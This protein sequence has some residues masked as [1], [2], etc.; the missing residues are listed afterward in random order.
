VQAALNA[1]GPA[2]VRVCAGTYIEALSITRD[3]NVI[4]AGDGGEPTT[5]TILSGAGTGNRVILIDGDITVT[6]QRVRVTG[7]HVT[8]PGAG[9]AVFNPANVNLV[10]CAIVGNTTT[11]SSASVSVGGG[12]FSNTGSGPDGGTIT[13]DATTRVTGNHADLV[14]G[15]GGGIFRASGTVTLSTVDNVSGNTPN[16]CR[17]VEVP[18]CS[19]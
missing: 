4:G 13:L 17:G 2:T 7:A 10:E 9:I 1:G 16:Q 14:A 11:N 6:L 18:L 3:V 5:D 12:I 19:G 15:G 8:F